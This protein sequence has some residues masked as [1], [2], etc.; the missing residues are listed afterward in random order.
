[1]TFTNR[2]LC[3]DSCKNLLPMAYI[4]SSVVNFSKCV[5]TCPAS[6]SYLDTTTDIKHPKC[7]ASCPADH[8]Y[9]DSLTTLGLNFCVDSCK[10]TIPK[11]FIDEISPG[12][13]PTCVVKCL[14]TAPNL[15]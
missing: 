10:K 1:M 3:I 12:K 9:I 13:L 5:R 4:D 6:L 7:V 14:P 2:K 8:K 15:D 11:S